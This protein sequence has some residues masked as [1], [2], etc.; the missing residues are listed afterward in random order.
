[1]FANGCRLGKL[2]CLLLGMAATRPAAA[3]E[4]TDATGRNKSQAEFV[5]LA[6]DVVRLKRADGTLVSVRLSR[7][8]EPD[9]LYACEESIRRQD[10]IPMLS[11][12]AQQALRDIVDAM[13]T[14]AAKYADEKQLDYEEWEEL[15]SAAR[16]ILLEK[17]DAL[18]AQSER[19]CAAS[20][21]VNALLQD[22]NF[23]VRLL[24][25]A[26][27]ENVGRAAAASAPLVAQLLDDPNGEVREAA[28]RRL[29]A[30]SL[31]TDMHFPTLTE[32]IA[33][34][35]ELLA[36]RAIETVSSSW[37]P[38]P[39]AL[40]TLAQWTTM[41]REKDRAPAV[42]RRIARA[43]V[44]MVDP[45][46]RIDAEQDPVFRIASGRDVWPLEQK[47]RARLARARSKG[48]ADA[49]RELRPLLADDDF[50]VQRA[51]VLMVAL[52]APAQLVDV[53]NDT[54]VKLLTAGA[55][56]REVDEED[57]A[58]EWHRNLLANQINGLAAT[59]KIPLR[60]SPAQL[61]AI[62]RVSDFTMEQL[63]DQQLQQ[64][65]ADVK[66]VLPELAKLLADPSIEVRMRAIEM[67]GSDFFAHGDDLASLPT[68]AVAVA[69]DAEGAIGELLLEGKPVETLGKLTTAIAATKVA[70]AVRE[71]QSV[72][73]ILKRALRDEEVA[74]RAIFALQSLETPAAA[75]VLRDAADNALDAD[76]RERARSA[77]EM[78]AG[79][80][81]GRIDEPREDPFAKPAA[82]PRRLAVELR[83][84]PTL[85]GDQLTLLLSAIAKGEVS[86]TRMLVVGTDG[87]TTR[88]LQVQAPTLA[89]RPEVDGAFCTVTL[90]QPK[91]APSPT[92]DFQAMNQPA[93]RRAPSLAAVQFTIDFLAAMYYDRDSHRHKRGFTGAGALPA[94]VLLAYDHKV[95]AADVCQAMVAIG[96]AEQEGAAPRDLVQWIRLKPADEGDSLWFVKVVSA[97]GK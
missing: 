54:L 23:A 72:E 52:H 65:G 44:R 60:F 96:A 85:R 39:R 6:G 63:V 40:A 24:G 57:K 80:D 31:D 70:P 76:V 4:W 38:G 79:D 61:A 35:D 37:L 53:P 94:T 78:L 28:Q 83:L 73:E 91:D 14:T 5:E 47:M 42:R 75:A 25:L 29:L 58:R 93:I 86:G 68:V 19:R 49:C 34:D 21:A 64:L 69:A 2:A 17:L 27:I 13:Q 56:E 90:A 1:M 10:E 9:Q 77:V 43:L 41:L 30:M 3:R 16:P 20:A 66:Q 36:E 15:L 46:D 7:L 45:P 26:A 62:I 18:F 67:L 89:E 71:E 32:Q 50:D 51:V 48:V 55:G 95:R 8:T 59:K 22:K 82:E 88:D 97:K 87:K 11:G 33:G 84:P 12:A 81:F 92:I 74:D